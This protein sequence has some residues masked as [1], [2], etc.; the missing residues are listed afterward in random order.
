VIRSEQGLGKC[1]EGLSVAVIFAV[2]AEI[3]GTEISNYRFP[4]KVS[5]PADRPARSDPDYESDD[6][7]PA[8]FYA[9]IVGI[10]RLALSHV[11]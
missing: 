8:S 10:F 6:F 11:R 9:S 4:A 2:E 1:R 7:I 3:F 5:G